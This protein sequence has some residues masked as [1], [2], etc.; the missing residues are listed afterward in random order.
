MPSHSSLQMRT[1]AGH[2]GRLD[3]FCVISP[4]GE[5][6][7]F[8]GAVGWKE[9]SIL[10]GGGCMEGALS[11][12]VAAGGDPH[13]HQRRTGRG[14]RASTSLAGQGI[15]AAGVDYGGDFAPIVRRIS[16]GPSSPPSVKG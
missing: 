1:M 10:R 4:A 2:G 16:N 6:F 14:K 9:L 12:S 11:R 3:S 13:G 5:F 15:L 8:P 7:C